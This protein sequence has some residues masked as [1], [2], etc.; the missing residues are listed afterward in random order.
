[1]KAKYVFDPEGRFVGI[2]INCPGCGDQHVLGIRPV[3]EG[4]IE[5]PHA[6]KCAHWLFTG[7]LEKPYFSPSVHVRTGHYAS[8][9]FTENECWCTYNKN[10]P[11]E[12]EDFAC[13]ICHSFIRDGV[14]EFLD[15]C[16]HALAGK[17]VALL[18]VE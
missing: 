7:D 18:D 4:L 3:P 14:I 9:N 1:M 17:K 8:G 15:D 6:I 13:Y 11:N 12:Q 2:R 16:T 10:H 5:S